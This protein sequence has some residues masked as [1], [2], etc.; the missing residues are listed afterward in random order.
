MNAFD[1]SR[2]R[3]LADSSTAL[4][5]GWATTNLPGVRAELVHARHASIT[6]V[7]FAFFTPEEAA[8]I[9][10]V[11]AQRSTMTRTKRERRQRAKAVILCCNGAETPR[12]LLLSSS[13][14][15]PNGLAN[16]SGLVG[17]YLMFTGWSVTAGVFDEPLNEFKSVMVTRVLHDFYEADATRG[18]YGGGGLDARFDFMPIG[19]ALSGLP[20]DVPR[21]GAE[22]KRTLRQYYTRTMTSRAT[23]RRYRS[24]PTRSRSTRP[25]RMRGGFQPCALP[26]A[27]I[28]T[29]SR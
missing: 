4:V 15:F 11:A 18:F 24:R 3:F 20:P 19:F 25:Y 7:A 2:R 17:K 23:L 27:T 21:W 10:A 26:T 22:F 28:R 8:D 13:S 6:P 5:A 14:R 1:R 12:L 9:T 16:A 29:T